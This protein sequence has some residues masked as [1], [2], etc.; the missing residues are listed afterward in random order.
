[1]EGGRACV[2]LWKGRSEVH[3]RSYYGMCKVHMDDVCNVE[4]VGMIEKD[5]PVWCE[6]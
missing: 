5:E 2:Y 4:E 6:M 1:M 3:V